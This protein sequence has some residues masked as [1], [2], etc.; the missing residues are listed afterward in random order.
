[1]AA[2]LQRMFREIRMN[3]N[4]SEQTQIFLLYEKPSGGS[5]DTTHY[6]LSL[7]HQNVD[8]IDA[9][10]GTRMAASLSP[11]SINISTKNFCK[12]FTCL[13][14]CVLGTAIERWL[15]EGGQKANLLTQQ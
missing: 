15:F 9:K 14:G 6:S 7:G 12:L 3:Y 1:M 2:N 11:S 10:I 5:F 8:L 13:F 4:S